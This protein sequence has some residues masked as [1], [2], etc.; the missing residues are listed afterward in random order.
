VA[1]SDLNLMMTHVRKFS[2]T[3]VLYDTTAADPYGPVTVSMLKYPPSHAA[4]LM[5]LV[6]RDIRGT[7]HGKTPARMRQY[8]QARLL[9]ILYLASLVAALGVVLVALRPGWKLAGLI[10]L[11]FLNWQ[12][13]WESMQGPQI[14]PFLLLL[15]ALS[16][17]L[18]KTGRVWMGGI[19][20][21]LAGDSGLSSGSSQGPCSPSRLRP[22]TCRRGS[23]SGT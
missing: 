11:F 5:A 18:L 20:I 17:A 6:P 19:P 16:L 23:P 12:P 10:T 8:L 7:A 3:G 15:F 2:E 1:F 14:E 13:H 22:S 21:G 9:M 4:F